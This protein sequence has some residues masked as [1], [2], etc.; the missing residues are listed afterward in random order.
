MEEHLVTLFGSEL[1]VNDRKCPNSQCKK[2]FPV[3]L[4]L[5]EGAPKF[6]YS[7]EVVVFD[8]ESIR[9]GKTRKKCPKCHSVLSI[10]C[11]GKAEVVKNL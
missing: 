10:P 7:K 5:Q 8:L 3:I 4:E 1:D 9:S 2:S 11:M 6:I